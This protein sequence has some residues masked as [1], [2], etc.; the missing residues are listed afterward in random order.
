MS[1]TVQG[2][3]GNIVF[4][5]LVCLISAIES[6]TCHVAASNIE[7]G[8]KEHKRTGVDLDSLV[9][10]SAGVPKRLRRID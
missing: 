10:G 3:R 8:R 5:F 1:F 9:L 7:T 6:I 4:I 2:R